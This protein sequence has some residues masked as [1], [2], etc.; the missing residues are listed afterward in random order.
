MVRE[1]QKILSDNNIQIS[2]T[3]VRVPVQNSHS[4]SILVETER[5]V[6]VAEARSLFENMPGVSVVDNPEESELPERSDAR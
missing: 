6:P 3:C 5:P 2:V 1:T 4:E